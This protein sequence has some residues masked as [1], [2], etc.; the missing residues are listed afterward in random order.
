M[1]RLAAQAAN[2]GRQ[3]KSSGHKTGARA[4][5]QQAGELR[6]HD[7]ANLKKSHGDDDV[8]N[9]KEGERQGSDKQERQ[10]YCISRT[11]ITLQHIFGD[12]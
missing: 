2:G 4:H 10:N 6:E 11:R 1:F 3:E 7:F 12:A 9:G 5:A 8:N